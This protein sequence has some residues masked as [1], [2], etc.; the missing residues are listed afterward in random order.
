MFRI[1]LLVALSLTLT[2]CANVHRTDYGVTTS[3]DMGA[4]RRTDVLGLAKVYAPPD[5]YE[6]EE[7]ANPFLPYAVAALNAYTRR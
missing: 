4:C 5:A 7:V 3:Q 1:I 6:Q 2:G